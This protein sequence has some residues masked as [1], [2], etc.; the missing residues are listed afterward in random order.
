MTVA[1]TMMGRSGR[2]RGR[3]Y[4][5]INSNEIDSVKDGGRRMIVTESIFAYIKS[6]SHSMVE[7]KDSS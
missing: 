6:L 5:L 7:D 1:Q 4:E 3:I 2:G